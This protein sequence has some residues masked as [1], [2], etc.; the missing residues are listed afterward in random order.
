MKDNTEDLA[1]GSD[2]T[3]LT[4]KQKLIGN[5][6]A[7]GYIVLC[8]LFLL[9]VGLKVIPLMLSD[10]ALPACLAAVGLALFTTGLI[11]RNP[12]SLW[13]SWAFNVPAVISLLAA[14]T[15]LTYAN[16]YPF[17]IA[18]PAVA[19]LLTLPMTPKSWKGHLK[20]IGFFGSFAFLFLL[21]SLIGVSWNVV[22][23][24]LLVY[25]GALVIFVAVMTLRPVKR[26]N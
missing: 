4:P 13:L 11:N 6:V 19:S 22:L 7:G 18:I 10:V 5:I 16:L 21:N 1:V 24:I 3:E 2:G 26:D 14:Y 15:S 17:Y 25:V 8:G 20:A 9:L 23:P 12:V